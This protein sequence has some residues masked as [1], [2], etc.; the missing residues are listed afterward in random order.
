MVGLS[1][2]TVTEIR[3]DH[4]LLNPRDLH[5]QAG[6]YLVVRANRLADALEPLRGG[7]FGMCEEWGKLLRPRGSEPCRRSRPACPARPR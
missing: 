1:N 5:H 2:P 6:H 4:P 3:G 7:E